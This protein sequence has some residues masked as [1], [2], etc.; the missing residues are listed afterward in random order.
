MPTLVYEEDSGT[1]ANERTSLGMT[2]LL[3][4]VPTFSQGPWGL[5]RATHLHLA[6]RALP[7]LTP[8]SLY[9]HLSNTFLFYIHSKNIS[10]FILKIHPKFVFNS[11]KESCLAEY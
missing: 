7:N 4:M 10:S 3:P 8:I 6:F 1:M 2:C 5:P 11:T 9:I